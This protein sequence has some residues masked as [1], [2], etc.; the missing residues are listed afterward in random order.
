MFYLE[1]DEPFTCKIR[2]LFEAESKEVVKTLSLVRW[3][4]IS[5]LFQN[6]LWI[7]ENSRPM[8]LISGYNVTDVTASLSLQ[9]RL[10]SFFF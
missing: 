5:V 2:P 3:L 10:I 8:V 6:E 9:T 4:A 1:N 7:M